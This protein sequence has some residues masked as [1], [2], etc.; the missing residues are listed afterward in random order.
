MLEILTDDVKCGHGAAVGSLDDDQR[1]Y[2]MSRGL[3]RFEAERAMV[4]GFFEDVLQ[5]VPVPGLTEYLRTVI[6]RK[7]AASRG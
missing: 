2:L 3:D 1:F 7:L 4:E 5:K 6:D